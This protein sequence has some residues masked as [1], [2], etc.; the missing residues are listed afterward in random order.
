[1]KKMTRKEKRRL[2]K[3]RRAGIFMA[4]I[5]VLGVL[6]LLFNTSFFKLDVIGVSGCKKTTEKEVVDASAFKY[7]ENIL[8]ANV[9]AAE[10]N[11]RKLPYVK[12]VQISRESK[13]KISI[14]IT[15]RDEDFSYYSGG[16]I[17][18]CDSEGRVLKRVE[19]TDVLPLV[20]GNEIKTIEPGDNIFEIDESLESLKVILDTARE[21]GEL[22]K[23]KEIRF[24]KNNEFGMLREGN[25]KIDFGRAE[26]IKYK[27]NFIVN[28][29][30]NLSDQGK[31][32]EIIKLNMD[33][34]VIVPKK[35]GKDEE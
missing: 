29:L 32:A 12:D 21:V 19:A 3:I 11:I 30:E 7:G 9:K 27:L 34:A 22:K 26:N 24:Q 1:M 5:S 4:L 20:K 13:N 35:E 14:V 18:I 31:S 15:E 28:A 6:Y 23:Y 2:E 33:P 16:K 17:Y 10:G 8:K 25:V